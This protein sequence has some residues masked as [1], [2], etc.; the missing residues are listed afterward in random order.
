A[1]ARDGCRAHLPL[2]RIVDIHARFGEE[3]IDG[4]AAEL[5][6]LLLHRLA[7]A[8]ADV[9]RRDLDGRHDLFSFFEA[10]APLRG[11]LR[12]W[13]RE[14]LTSEPARTGGARLRNRG[15]YFDGD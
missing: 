1:F 15:L 3:A 9:V 7:G 6:L 13:M 12:C 10:K 11:A 2:T 14:L 4:D 5:R 8:G